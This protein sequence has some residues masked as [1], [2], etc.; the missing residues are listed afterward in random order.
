MSLLTLW[1]LRRSL[2][3]VFNSPNFTQL[4]SGESLRLIIQIK[5][6]ISRYFSISHDQPSRF[7]TLEVT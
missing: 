1:L 4:L 7:R 5:L 2:D 6:W 3:V